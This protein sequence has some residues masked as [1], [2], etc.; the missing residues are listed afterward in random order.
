MDWLLIKV[1]ERGNCG[2][3]AFLKRGICRSSSVLAMGPNLRPGLC[4][5]L[6]RSFS[7]AQ[8]YYRSVPVSSVSDKNKA[9]SPFSGSDLHPGMLRVPGKKV[10]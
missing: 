4:C 2:Q 6:I 7:V 10:P 1:Q 9:C 8:S 3:I 5:R